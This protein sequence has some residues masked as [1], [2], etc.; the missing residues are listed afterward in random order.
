MRRLLFDGAAN[1]LARTKNLLDRA[2]KSAAERLVA[3]RPGNF[4]NLIERNVAAVSHVLNLLAVTRRL[5]QGFD[6]E[7]RGRG[8]H[9]NSSLTVLNR[10]LDR[11]AQTLPLTRSLGNVFTDLLGGLS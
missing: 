3:H 1:T 8:H 9:G 10:E 4:N 2:G 7:R 6:H 5:L 11:H